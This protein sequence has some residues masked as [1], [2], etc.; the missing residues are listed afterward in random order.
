M[1]DNQ[2]N[3]NLNLDLTLGPSSSTTTT[4]TTSPSSSP[5]PPPPT[6][7]PSPSPRPPPPQSSI[8]PLPPPPIFPFSGREQFQYYLSLSQPPSSPPQPPP[9]PDNQEDRRLAGSGPVRAPRR[10]QGPILRKGQSPTIPPPFPW[11]TNQRAVIHSLEGLASK[12]I[13]TITGQVQCKQCNQQYNMSYDLQTVFGTIR[14]FLGR[15]LVNLYDRAPKMWMNPVLP[16]C[17]HC[18]QR[19][20]AKPIMPIKKRQINWLFLLLGQLLGCC[21]LNQLKYFCKHS[22][23]HRTGAKDR[24]VYLA[25]LGLSKQLDPNG[26]FDPN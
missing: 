5:P 22:N 14:N 6:T 8:S 2:E 19:N 1:E 7:T 20:A 10:N 3:S 11:A 18:G 9:Q 21:T 4:P 25:Y 26:P 13:T 24:L 12:G 23:I 16:R 17:E 15:E